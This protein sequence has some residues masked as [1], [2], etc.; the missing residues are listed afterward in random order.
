MDPISPARLPVAP[1][2][3][4]MHPPPNQLLEV[5]PYTKLVPRKARFAPSPARVVP[6]LRTDD[7]TV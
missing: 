5:I 2:C 1:G 3:G 4:C 7:G 6:T